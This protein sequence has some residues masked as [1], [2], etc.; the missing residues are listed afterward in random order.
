MTH[1][2]GFFGVFLFHV[3]PIRPSF[4]LINTS[5]RKTTHLPR[6]SRLLSLSLLTRCLNAVCLFTLWKS[7]WLMPTINWAWKLMPHISVKYLK[8]H[9]Y[10][11]HQQPLQLNWLQTLGVMA[12]SCIALVSMR[13][14]VPCAVMALLSSPPP[15]L[16]NSAANLKQC[17]CNLMAVWKIY[18]IRTDVQRGV[19]V[20][21]CL[22]GLE[23]EQ[24]TPT[25]FRSKGISPLRL[26]S[27][28]L[29]EGPWGLG[30]ILRV[31]WIVTDT[32]SDT[33]A[34]PQK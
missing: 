26:S 7:L 12:G 25:W 21:Q 29:L 13:D 18:W 6:V 5:Q 19:A 17:P 34:D 3:L 31:T 14:S 15:S 22:D 10:E 27:P 33:R 20:T 30:Q 2:W 1:L 32:R 11:L 28:L 8:S 4:L 23:G 16:P 24:T 9:S